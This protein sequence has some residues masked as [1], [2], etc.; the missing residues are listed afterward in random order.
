MKTYILIL[1]IIA[2]INILAA[3]GLKETPYA[4]V[5]AGGVTFNYRVTENLLNLDCQLIANTT[6]WV[7][8]GFSPVNQMQGANFIIGY[9]SGGNTFIRDDY[10]T[11]AT[12]HASDT[13]LGG[14]NNVLTSSSSETGG[15]TQLN[16]VIPLNS[17]DAFD[18]V[19]AIGQSYSIILGRGNNGG[20]NFTSGHAGVGSAQI[21]ITQPVSNEDD[22]L[23]S[24]VPV[25]S[26]YP[27]PFTD[28]AN[29]SMDL[30]STA[31][32]S[33]VIYNAKGQLV[34]SLPAAVYPKGQ[35]TLVW[36]GNDDSGRSLPDG[37]Y[38]L[39]LHGNGLAKSHK[40][41]LL[42]K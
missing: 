27:N 7:S 30:K 1:I 6:G 16:F 25:I 11:S 37:V 20:D 39:K 32:L 23:Q 8:V 4:T 14:T 5:T 18:K 38:F 15:V 17:G 12:T 26:S 3:N 10:G 35:N 28:V 9:H 13:S 41:L 34:R 33:P 40:L 19:L 21:S 24:A 22:F 2:G 42:R 29:I 36:N 31:N